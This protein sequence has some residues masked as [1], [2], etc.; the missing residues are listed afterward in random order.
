MCPRRWTVKGDT[1]ASF[2]NDHD[3]PMELWAWYTATL[4]D[5]EMKASVQGAQAQM[6]IFKFFFLVRI[7][8]N[9]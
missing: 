5:T 6:K 4:K 3:E 2:C 8:S 7:Y 1:L 9:K